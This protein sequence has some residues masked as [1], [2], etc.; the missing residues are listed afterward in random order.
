MSKTDKSR[1]YSVSLIKTARAESEHGSTWG[2]QGKNFIKTHTR[3]TREQSTFLITW[4]TLY[5]Y[6]NLWDFLSAIIDIWFSPKMKWANH[7]NWPLEENSFHR[8]KKGKVKIILGAIKIY[9]LIRQMPSHIKP[10]SHM[11]PCGT[12][13]EKNFQISKP[14]SRLNHTWQFI[15]WI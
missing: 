13:E 2:R 1:I 14:E 8:G 12:G 10:T 15:Y 7:N 3:L 9:I 6:W 5:P 11:F 4:N